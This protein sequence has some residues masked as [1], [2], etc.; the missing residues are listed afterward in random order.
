MSEA[1]LYD[2]PGPVARRRTRVGTSVGAVLLAL[3]AGLV[4]WRL[5]DRGQ[6]DGQKWETFLDPD[7]WNGIRVG[8]TN[9]LKAAL[10]AIVLAV[11]LGVLLASGRLSERVFIRAPAVTVIEFFRAIPLLMLI[12][13]FFLA[14]PNTLGSYG[15]LVA[16]LTLYNGSVLAEIFRAGIAAVPRGQSEAAFSLGMRK[17]AVMRL[18][19]VPQAV[20]TMLPAIVSQCVVVLKDTSLGFIVVYPELLQVA[21]QIYVGEFNIIPTVM[22]VAPI[23]IGMNMSLSWFAHWLERRQRQRYGKEAVLSADSVDLGKA[24]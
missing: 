14:F 1:V 17:S 20:R 24:L 16:G 2:H 10:V 13:F 9:T 4:L 18:V 19:L 11:V 15:A 3:L 5:V 21:K 23:Y 6:F 7:T 22:V 8:L 12:F